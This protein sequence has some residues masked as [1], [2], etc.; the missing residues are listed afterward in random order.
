MKHKTFT[1][2][3]SNISII[4]VL[5]II[6]LSHDNGY[7][8]SIRFID[9]TKAAG[10]D[11]FRH[12]LGNLDKRWIIDAMG[13]GVAV[14]DYD[15]DGDDDIYFV[16]GRPQYD[17]PNEHYQNALFRNDAGV[18]TDTTTSAGVGDMGFGM[19]AIFGDIDN[20][21]W[22]DLFVGNYGKNVLYKNNGD[23]TFHEATAACGLENNQYAASACF[24]DVDNDGD[25]DLFVG[26]YV[27]FDP[28]E[29][30]KL[31]AMY[32]GQKVLMGPMALDSQRDLL[33]LND[34]TGKFQN[35]SAKAMINVSRGRAMGSVFFDMEN[36]GDPDLYVTN[37][38]TYNHILQNNGAGVFEDLSFLS[39]GGFSDSGRGGASMGVSSG[40]YNNDGF[41]DLLITSYERESDMLYQNQ[42]DGILSDETAFAGLFGATLKRVTWGS[43]FCDFDADGWLDIYT[44]NGHVYPQVDNLKKSSGYK[45]GASIYRNT[46][47]R[48]N[49]ISKAA[50]PRDIF[51][52]SGRGSA[53][54]DY[55][56]D[57]DMDIVIN[58]M[59]STPVLL[60]NQS[61]L[62]NWLQ[63]K[64][65]GLSAQTYCVRV[66]AKRDDKSWS[67]S[68]DGG[69]GYLSQNSQIIHFGFGEIDIIDELI[70]YWRHKKPQV[71]TCP[72][73]NQRLII[74]A[75]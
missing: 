30:G 21:G 4:L 33:Y 40:D 22:L 10:L 43:G 46:S 41:F 44:A 62:G 31:Y 39:G 65:D 26:N 51:S 53:L 3:P 48:F 64:L 38:S 35:A 68:I 75:M 58:C 55:D 28:K 6:L 71:I 73:L 11:E 47:K 45:Q 49:D 59:D 9:K 8:D 57:G 13:S 69:S 60:E 2:I 63:V 34:G 36:D 5:I 52:K 25:L 74:P 66:V 1:H 14:G 7:C 29:H 61:E 37:D 70:I 17:Q 27:E 12:R 50:L 54:L 42:G 20:D 15:N 24:V 16:N 32:L 23:G 56:N 18:F 67:R 19:C 72:D